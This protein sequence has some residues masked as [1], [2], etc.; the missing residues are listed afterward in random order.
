MIGKTVREFLPVADLLPY[1]EAIVSVYNRLGR[2]D[3]KYKARIKITVHENGIDD[4]P[5]PDRGPVRRAAAALRR[6]GDGRAGGNRGAVRAARLRRTTRPRRSSTRCC[7]AFVDTNVTA[8]RRDDHAIVTVSL[9][10]HG[11]TPGD[12][13]ADQMRLMADLAEAHAYGELRISHEQNVILPHVRR[14]APAGAARRAHAPRGSAPR[15]SGWRRDIIACPGMDYCALATARSIPVA[16][17]I[18]TRIDALKIEHE[19]GHAEDQDLGLHQ[20]LRSPPRRPYRHPRAR[21][22]GRREL[23]DHAGRRPYRD[24]RPSASARARASPTTQIVPAIERLI[25]AYLDLRETARRDLHRGLSPPRPGAVQGRP[26]PTGEAGC[27][28][29]SPPCSPP[30]PPA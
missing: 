16:Q 21:P 17:E 28:L 15:M 8:H 1:C 25:L 12:A 30:A 4:D 22:G 18:A 13:T 7:A 3:N 14:D 19:V 26:L 23:P 11:A 10:A 6:L 24:A 29:I 20:R 27:R 2:R 5:R 9:K